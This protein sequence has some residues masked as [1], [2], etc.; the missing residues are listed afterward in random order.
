MN[1]ACVLFGLTPEEALLGVTANAARALGLE[2]PRHDRAWARGPIS[3]SG[4]SS[5]RAT[6]P[7][8]WASIPSLPSSAMAN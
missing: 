3:P 8:R 6:S 7:I 1:M 2:G 4:T 5:G